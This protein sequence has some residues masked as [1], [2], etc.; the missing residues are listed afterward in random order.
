MIL[1]IDNQ[2]KFIENIKGAIEE[3]NLECRICKHSKAPNLKNLENVQGLI[4]S[5]GPG[6]PYGPLNITADLLALMSFDVPTLGICLGHEIIAVANK[7]R[8]SRLKQRQNKMENVFIDEK[9]DVIF[10]GLDNEIIIRKKH[11]RHVT[12]VP[13][14]FKVIAHSEACPVEVIK[15]KE[16]SIYGFQ[17][18]PEVSGDQGYIIMKN[19]LEIC[20]ESK[21]ESEIEMPLQLK[22]IPA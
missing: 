9:Q 3:N 10:K 14:N 22:Q 13:K 11:Y 6:D 12:N 7:G 18:H 4:L 2:S 20:K 8:I 16:K 5:G 21:T 1:V 15:H 17:G 19:F